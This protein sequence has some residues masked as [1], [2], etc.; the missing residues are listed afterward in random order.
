MF[1]LCINLY[2]NKYI[3]VLHVSMDIG[4]ESIK[5]TVRNEE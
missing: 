1:I 5:E 4:N 2:I 3:C